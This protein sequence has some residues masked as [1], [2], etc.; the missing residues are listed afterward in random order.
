MAK[1][2]NEAMSNARPGVKKTHNVVGNEPVAEK[3]NVRS[4][5]AGLRENPLFGLLK[6]VEKGEHGSRSIRFEPDVGASL[7]PAGRFLQSYKFYY[8]ALERTLPEISVMARGDR[9]FKYIK[10][11]RYT[12][13]QH[14]LA[15]M[16]HPAERYIEY[17][18]LS[19]LLFSRILADRTIALAR[20]FLSE[21]TL[22]SF[23]SFNDHKKFFLK[24]QGQYGDD[25]QYA[26][27]MRND[28]AWFDSLK[29]VRDDFVVHHGKAK[30]LRL[31]GYG[32]SDN[33]VTLFFVAYPQEDPQHMADFETH[34]KTIQ[35]QLS[36]RRLAGD[37]NGFL[38]WFDAYGSKALREGQLK[39]AN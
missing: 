2:R 3:L 22:P 16:Y 26:A 29:T 15:K 39:P 14:E 24:L 13:F 36:V 9:I 31:L 25:E 21:A 10:G 30:Y 33:D 32:S 6:L 34:Y 20:Y 11:C 37:I 38:K 8:L 1:R 17:D 27:Y 28:T 4:E 19:C 5:L 35:V 7:S 12:P 23:T 18:L